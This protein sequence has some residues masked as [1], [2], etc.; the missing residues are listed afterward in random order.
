MAYSAAWDE[1]APPG[2]TTPDERAG[3]GLDSRSRCA[4]DTDSSAPSGR[5]V[6][7]N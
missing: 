6:Y 2:S 7:D 3:G 5:G 4:E 1:T